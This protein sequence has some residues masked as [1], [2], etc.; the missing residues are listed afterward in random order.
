MSLKQVPIGEIADYWRLVRPML[1]ELEG[2]DAADDWVQEDIY[3]ACVTGKAALLVNDGDWKGFVVIEVY[4]NFG[5][6]KLHVWVASKAKNVETWAYW[7]DIQQVARNA[8]CKK[9][10]FSSKLPMWDRHAQK[11]G[12][13]KGET[14]YWQPVEEKVNGR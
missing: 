1:I 8:G 10:T 4:P 3:V 14:T 2:R 13:V 9:I 11:Y 5:K 6:P 7:E 12:F